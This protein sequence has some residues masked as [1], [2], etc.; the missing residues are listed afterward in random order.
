MNFRFL[1]RRFSTIPA[2]QCAKPAGGPDPIFTSSPFC[3]M[4][5]RQP[6]RRRGGSAMAELL[7]PR[8]IVSM[9]ARAAN[10]LVAGGN[11]DAACSICTCWPGA[12][13][14][15]PPRP[16]G[17]PL[18]RG[19]AGGGVE[20]P[21]VP[22][23]GGRQCRPGPGGPPPG[24]A[25]RPAGLHRRR[26]HQGAGGQDLHLPRPGERGAA[27]A[28]KILSTADLKSLY[29]LYDYLALPAEVIC[30]LV[31]WCVEEFARK[32]GPGRKP[33]M[34]QIQKEGFVW[35]R[36]GVDTAQAAE[37]HLKKQA[38]TAAGRGRSSAC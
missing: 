11:G 20:G 35:H 37:E 10:R 9:T 5:M 38:S 28:G 34:S 17:P 25:P 14:W 8:E 23:P 31:S 1:G 4:I 19:P 36:L 2:P 13:N 32:Y 15:T 7:L 22:G 21:G 12:G 29:T 16:E 27:A 18:G 30:L 6:H 33:R 26:H 3:G 24:G